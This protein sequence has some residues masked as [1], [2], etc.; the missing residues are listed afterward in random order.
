M[1]IENI[2]IIAGQGEL[3]KVIAEGIKKNGHK[4][5]VLTFKQAVNKDIVTTADVFNEMDIGDVIGAVRFL[6]SNNVTKLILVGRIPHKL[7]FAKLAL[8]VSMNEILSST[9]DHMAVSIF[10]SARRMFAKAGIEVVPYIEYVRHLLAEK[11]VMTALAPGE[12]ELK[13]IEFGKKLAKQLADIDIGQTVIVKDGTVI[14]VEAMEGTDECI[15]RAQIIVGTAVRGVNSA[16]VV[17]VARTAQDARFDI[18]VIGKHTVETLSRGI[19]KVLAVEA[20]KTLILDKSSVLQY[21]A[22]QGVCIYGCE[23]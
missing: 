3:P 7:L 19:I 11:G 6:K 20:G 21:A 14:A 15:Q 18:P 8:D 9:K 22:Q 4:T 10:D 5:V 12:C 2:G 13:D 23:I 16:V 17:K 1:I